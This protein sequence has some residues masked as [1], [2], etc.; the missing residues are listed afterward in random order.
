M[1]CHAVF[2][3]DTKITHWQRVFCEYFMCLFRFCGFSATEQVENSR[4]WPWPQLCAAP[5]LPHLAAASKIPFFLSIPVLP[6]MWIWLIYTMPSQKALPSDTRSPTLVSALTS[7]QLHKTTSNFLLSPN[8]LQTG[9]FQNISLF[10][11]LPVTAL[12]RVSCFSS[13]WLSVYPMA[14]SNRTC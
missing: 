14:F 3:T 9:T 5:L 4:P 6:S 2:A 11:L 8:P 7:S 1:S 10:S 13:H 12:S